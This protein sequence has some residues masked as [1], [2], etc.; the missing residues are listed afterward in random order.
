M[1]HGTLSLFKTNLLASNMHHGGNDL[2]LIKVH[3]LSP[4]RPA[5]PLFQHNLISLIIK[6]NILFKHDNII[7]HPSANL[8]NMILISTV[9]TSLF[10][11]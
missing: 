10:Q 7:L 3:K 2:H 5:R 1:H 6:K 4:R 8:Q 9:L 11:F